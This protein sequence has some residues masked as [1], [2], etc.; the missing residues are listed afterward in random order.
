MNKNARQQDPP[1]LGGITRCLFETFFTL[2]AEEPVKRRVLEHL[3]AVAHK[4]APAQGLQSLGGALV[5]KAAETGDSQAAFFLSLVPPTVR[6]TQ[7]PA[8]RSAC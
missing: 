4:A 1:P 6:T 5:R 7:T 3:I 2:D 8:K